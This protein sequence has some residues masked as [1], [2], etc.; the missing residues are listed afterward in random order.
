MNIRN[1]Y[2]LFQILDCTGFSV[3]L[4]HEGE[5]LHLGGALGQEVLKELLSLP[6]FCK[7]LLRR[8]FQEQRGKNGGYAERK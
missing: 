4:Q 6:L 5:D 7:I 1:H 3:Q 2:G 8:R